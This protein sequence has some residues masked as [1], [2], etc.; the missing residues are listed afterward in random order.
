MLKQQLTNIQLVPSPSPTPAKGADIFAGWKT[1]TAKTLNLEFKLPPLFNAYGQLQENIE[2]GEKG[3]ALCMTFPPSASIR[4]IHPVMAG[5]TGC[6][7][8]T[9][10][11]GTISADYEAGRGGSFSDILG[12]IIQNGKY[13]GRQKDNSTFALP[14]ELTKL[15][16]NPDGIQMVKIIGK[17]ETTGE[18]RGPV[19]GTP[20]DG[21]IGAIFNTK[22]STYPGITV[23]MKV[24]S[25]LTEDIFDQI[26]S[27]FKFTNKQTL[28]GE[29]PVKNSWTTYTDKDIAFEIQYPENWSLRKTYGASIINLGNYRVSGVDISTNLSVGSTL[30][31]N[32]IDPKGVSFENWIKL[33]SGETNPPTSPNSTYI[34]LPSYRF[35]R[36]REGKPAE[37]LTYFMPNE[38]Y[39]V[40]FA[41]NTSL[42]DQATADQILS[43]FKLLE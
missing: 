14:M 16:N 1:Y 22:N 38:K 2:P 24:T 43:T 11:L 26:L 3:T 42:A 9:F 39:I 36:L 10:G 31:V 20:G 13:Y 4:F 8:N 23:E 30:V 6:Q 5:G 25:S 35:E 21:K 32:I 12:F 28:V 27:T 15:I 7:I 34:N 33:Y 41:S 37:I 18:W 29:A 19:G 40:F 17:N